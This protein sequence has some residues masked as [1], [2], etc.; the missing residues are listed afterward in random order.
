MVAA[1]VAA[2]LAMWAVGCSPRCSSTGALVG[3]F[4]APLAAQYTFS[5]TGSNYDTVMSLFSDCATQLTCNDDTVGLT[6]QVV[7]NM[8]A[9]EVVLVLVDGYNGATG[10]WTLNITS[11]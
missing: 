1:R 3:R 9:G 7:R 2:T 10:N 4:T 8:A 11:P 6:S 5:T